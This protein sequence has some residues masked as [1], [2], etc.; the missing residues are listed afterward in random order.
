MIGYE[1]RLMIDGYRWMFFMDVYMDMT[2][3]CH[4]LGVAS[5]FVASLLPDQDT[6]VLFQGDM[7][8]LRGAQ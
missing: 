7:A 8:I 3:A 2:L 1:S 4:G 6:K 5:C